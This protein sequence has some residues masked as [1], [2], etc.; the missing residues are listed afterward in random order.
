MG[1][2]EWAS[3]IG[4]TAAALI[5]LGGSGI[6]HALSYKDNK[7]LMEQQQAWQEKMSNTAMQRGIEDAKNRVLIQY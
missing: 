7:K 4:S 5:G 1:I 3:A 6:S 2:G